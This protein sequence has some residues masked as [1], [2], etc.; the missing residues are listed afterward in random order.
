MDSSYWIESYQRLQDPQLLFGLAVR[1]FG[2]FIVLIIVMIGIWLLG[3]LF[4]RIES[5]ARSRGSST[6]KTSASDQSGTPPSG[7]ALT[8]PAREDSIP[9]EVVAAIALQIE[10]ARDDGTLA[11]SVTPVPQE[12]AAAISLALQASEGM[13]EVPTQGSGLAGRI[14]TWQEAEGSWKLMGR[15]EAISRNDPW[16]G[17]WGSLRGKE[18][19]T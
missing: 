1:F 11:A 5:S 17:R 19:K 4:R 12:V 2:V 18:P 6:A 13:C 14:T 15:Q 16:A 3:H 9:D 8:E 7:R 10:K